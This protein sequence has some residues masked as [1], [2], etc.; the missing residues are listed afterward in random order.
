MG[1][2]TQVEVRL[3]LGQKRLARHAYQGRDC[4][5][6]ERVLILLLQVQEGQRLDDTLAATENGLDLL[7]SEG[8]VTHIR[9]CNKR[10]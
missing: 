1:L 10:E 7:S 4:T 9:V 8:T 5:E 2:V 6:Q 3:H